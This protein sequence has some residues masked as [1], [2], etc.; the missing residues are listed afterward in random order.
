MILDDIT[1][2][3]RLRLKEQKERLSLSDLIV[4]SEELT[5]STKSLHAALTEGADTAIIA[6]VKKASPSRG[7]IR[8]D[9]SHTEIAREYLKCD[10]QAM[11]VLT[12]ED[13]FLGSPNFLA[14]ISEF[15]TVPLLRKDFIIDEYQ[16]YEA[17]LLGADAILLIC[18][19]LDDSELERFSA[20]AKLLGMECLVETH[21]R[22]EVMRAAAVGARI[23]GI[24]NRNLYDFSEDIHTT[25]KL[26]KYLPRGAAAVSESSIKTA[27]DLKYL[28]GI[29]ADAVLI[30]EQFMRSGNI[31]K[32]V[33]EIRGR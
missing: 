15:S 6:E 24:N 25:E 28:A 16:I 7:L 19:I 21:D 20:L 31:F 1:A 18:A 23:I 32:A 11:S 27:A 14:E 9:F 30:G 22:D 5:R 29:G 3:K 13:F 26:I 8:P 10:I 17:Y 33:E 4:A 2:K 12:E